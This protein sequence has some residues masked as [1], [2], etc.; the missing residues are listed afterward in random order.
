MTNSERT[1]FYGI[2]NSTDVKSYVKNGYYWH[3]VKYSARSE[4]HYRFRF[5]NS[6]LT[7]HWFITRKDEFTRYT[8]EAN[9]ILLNK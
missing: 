4:L 2:M 7:I 8:P 3:V 1:I 5:T 9:I 6:R